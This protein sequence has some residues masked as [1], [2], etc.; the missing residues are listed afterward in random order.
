[1]CAGSN[2]ETIDGIPELAHDVEEVTVASGVSLF[3]LVGRQKLQ[4]AKKFA[5]LE[6]H[7]ARQNNPIP[8]ANYATVIGDVNYGCDKKEVRRDKKWLYEDFKGCFANIKDANKADEYVVIMFVND[9]Q[10]NVW[11][12]V[13]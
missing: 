7:S 5:D 2:L 13:F 11:C 4:S 3:A 12:F 6:R 8:E 9:V 1:M 10:I